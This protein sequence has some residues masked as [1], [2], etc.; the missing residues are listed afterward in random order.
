MPQDKISARNRETK[1]SFT[2][3]RQSGA[4]AD[5]TVQRESNADPRGGEK[6]FRAEL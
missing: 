1:D 6:G 2:P 3:T 4:A 5:Q